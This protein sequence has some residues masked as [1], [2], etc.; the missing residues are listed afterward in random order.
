MSRS[1]GATPMTPIMGFKSRDSLGL[2]MIFLFSTGSRLTT[3]FFTSL[4]RQPNSGSISVT[5]KGAREISS[6][7]A[8]RVSPGLAS[9]TKIGPVA[10]FN[11]SKSRESKELSSGTSLSLKQS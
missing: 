3:G 9:S 6:M 7:S 1:A 2:K 8:L 5:P 10:G 4:A 11:S